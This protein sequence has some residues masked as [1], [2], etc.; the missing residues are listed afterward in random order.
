MLL[1]LLQDWFLDSLLFMISL[2][3]PLLTDQ[4]PPMAMRGQFRSGLVIPWRRRL[5]CPRWGKTCWFHQSTWNKNQSP[6]TA[7]GHLPSSRP[8]KV[9]V[10]TGLGGRVSRGVVRTQP[11]L[12][13]SE[14]VGRDVHTD[15]DGLA[16]P[17]L[18]HDDSG[19]ELPSALSLPGAP[20]V[21]GVSTDSTPSTILVT[22][23]VVTSA[24]G[25]RVVVVSWGGESK[26]PGW[27]S[28]GWLYQSSVRLCKTKQLCEYNKGKQPRPHHHFLQLTEQSGNMWS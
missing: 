9:S 2:S 23:S 5:R 27:C 26:P 24:V 11:E 13:V 7:R 19:A 20:L 17:V 16:R 4:D 18:P 8:E 21:P 1:L 3:R 28:R 10:K 15:P 12:E 22:M 6:P 25:L 14:V